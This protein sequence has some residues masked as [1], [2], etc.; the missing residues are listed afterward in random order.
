MSRP[1]QDAQLLLTAAVLAAMAILTA[2]SVRESLAR[3]DELRS[4]ELKVCLALEDI[5]K[6]NDNPK[7][8]ELLD[9]DK[10]K[11]PDTLAGSYN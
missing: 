4:I 1:V 5:G 2:P 6:A 3:V 8:H 10:Q 11:M 9:T 7:C